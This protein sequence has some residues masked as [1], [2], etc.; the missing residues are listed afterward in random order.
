MSLREAAL[1]V[2][3]QIEQAIHG[4]SSVYTRDELGSPT[5][6]HI[7]HILDHFEVLIAGVADEAI[8]YNLR[9]RESAAETKPIAALDRLQKI[10]QKLVPIDDG[11]VV[12]VETEVSISTHENAVLPST[13]G[14]ELAYVISH[15]IHHLAQ[16]RLMAQ[17]YGVVLDDQLGIAPA[18]ASYL[19]AQS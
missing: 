16:I 6:K 5:G 14:R 19:R 15:S 8:N 13:Y 18:T 12:H 2:L 11:L 7:R 3:D 4:V 10:K 17:C 1:E 9:S